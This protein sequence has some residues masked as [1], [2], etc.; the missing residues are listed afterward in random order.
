M[1]NELIPKSMYRDLAVHTP[2]NMVLKQFFSEIASIEDFEQLQLSLYQVR[3]HLISQHQDIV[4][5]L[6]SN[7]ITKALGF[8]LMQDKASSSGG[9]FLRWRT[10]IRQANQSAEKGGLIWKGLVEDRTLSEG[11]KKRIAQMEKERL[12]LNMQ[13]SVLNS[14]MRQL[15][16]T[17]DKL[18]EIEAIT[19]GEML[20]N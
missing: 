17:I 19:Q 8:R 11:I 3:A 20:S 14:M 4:K 2:L 13:M 18:T 5:K 16:A 15:S 9:H 6:R 1:K 12:V 10:T 7:D